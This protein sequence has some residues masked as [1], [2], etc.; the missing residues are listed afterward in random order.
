MVL[1]LNTH[2]KGIPLII[3]PYKEHPGIRYFKLV[4]MNKLKLLMK[5]L[6][7]MPLL[8]RYATQHATK[9]H[10]KS[11][12]YREANTGLYRG[13]PHNIQSIRWHQAITPNQT[14]SPATNQSGHRIT[15]HVTR[16]SPMSGLYVAHV[17]SPAG[18]VQVAS[19]G[20]PVTLTNQGAL[21]ESVGGF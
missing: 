9:I 16:H 5:L 18:W 20:Y 4:E 8:S 14:T 12:I 1:H 6:S 19:C 17:F 2:F 3:C 13:A 7:S 21:F 11:N 15:S 10:K